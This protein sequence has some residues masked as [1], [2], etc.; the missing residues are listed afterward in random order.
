M[1][2]Y[3]KIHERERK[4]MGMMQYG[5]LNRSNDSNTFYPIIIHYL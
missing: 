5:I 3:N 2:I 1:E 4:C